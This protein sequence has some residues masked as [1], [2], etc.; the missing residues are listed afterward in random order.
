MFFSEYCEI[1]K[2]TYFEK[3]LLTAAPELNYR[4][5]QT[6]LMFCDHSAKTIYRLFPSLKV[7]RTR[8]LDYD[9]LQIQKWKQQICIT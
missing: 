5:P 4:Q 8:S 7:D 6:L 9:H 3:H 1:F 2:N